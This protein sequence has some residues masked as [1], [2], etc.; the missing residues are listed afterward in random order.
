MDLR[1]NSN[2]VEETIIAGEKFSNNLIAGDII[3]ITGEIGSGKTHF[4][5]GIAKGFNFKRA[6]LSPTFTIVNEYI[7]GKLPIYHF[8]CFRIK[9]TNELKE[10]GIDNY[11]FG[12]G[13]SVIEWGEVV[14]EFLPLPRYLCQFSYGQKSNERL[15][16]IKKLEK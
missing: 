7:G 16:K 14:E 8:D 11:L 5:K 12:D 10:I 15:I 13:V 4:V 1:I 9:N 3:E 6:A 2:S